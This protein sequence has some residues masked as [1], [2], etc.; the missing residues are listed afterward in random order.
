MN[1]SKNLVILWRI[2]ISVHHES[3]AQKVMQMIYLCNLSEEKHCPVDVIFQVID[4]YKGK[5]IVKH[6]KMP[7]IVE[8]SN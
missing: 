8:R 4:S 6:Y 1:D 3:K 2:I 7:L 5:I